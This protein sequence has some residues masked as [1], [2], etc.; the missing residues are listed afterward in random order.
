MQ[1][2]LQRYTVKRWAR[3]FLERLRETRALR[4]AL[5]TRLLAGELAD[6]MLADFRDAESRLLLLDYDGTL[7]SF[8][9]SPSLARP[10]GELLKMLEAFSRDPKT[11]PVLIS[12]RDHAALDRWFGSLALGII[13]E[14][15]A[16]V[17]EPG[18]EWEVDMQV[19]SG[20]KAWIREIL[21]LFV[22][23]TPGSFIEEKDF[24]LSW[25]YRRSDPSLGEARAN[26]LRTE[27][28]PLLEDGT[29]EI[30]EGDRVME[31][32]AS[33]VN[34]GTAAHR[35]VNRQ[36]WEFI[37]A[38]GDDRTDEHLFRA[39][40]EDVYSIK[41]GLGPSWAEYR[42]GSTGAV[43]Q[44]LMRCLQTLEERDD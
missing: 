22:D 30:L 31:V 2:R 1:E 15:G 36:D 38:V 14:H 12:G 37:M 33:G 20:W 8:A 18:G 40:P 41:V 42:V 39:L 26:E 16:W 34:K 23:R 21:N 28:A 9:S 43:R 32:R 3:D 35:F 24:S 44:L 27:I 19:E 13:A 10:D 17:R 29:F 7:V 11:T 4:E 5:T 25:H 6:S